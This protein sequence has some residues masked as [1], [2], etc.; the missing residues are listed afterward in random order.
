MMPIRLRFV[1]LIALVAVWL[2]SGCAAGGRPADATDRDV[3]L[4]KLEAVGLAAGEKL[5]V[6]ATTGLVGDVVANVAGDTIELTTLMAPGQDPHGFQPTPR[7]LAAVERAHVVF[8]NGFHLEEGLESTIDA[9]S[10]RGRPVVAISAG[11]RPRGT[12]EVHEGSTPQ[13]AGT[14]HAHV[15]GDPHVWFDPAN[16]KIWAQNVATSLSA[17]DPAHAA[18][19][20]ANAAAYAG[21]LDELDAFIRA[22]VARIPA[23]R[24]KLVTDHD[25]FGYFA[26]RYGFRVIGAVIPALSTTA[27]PSAGDLAD[28]ITKIRAERVPAVF[29]GSQA[30]ARL[31]EL[32]A[33]ETGAR[34]LRLYTGELGPAGSGAETYIGMM[35]VDVERIVDGLGQP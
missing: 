4:P 32:V 15:A 12:G 2:A 3:R 9:A 14:D 28:L 25:A 16:V 22:Q 17:L 19:Y 29:I 31:P 35:R 34:V 30:N 20:Q 10:S 6:V 26:D 33:A 5:R 18:A 13:A 11:I 21:Q 7:D 8:I 27:E 23:E 24:R 1:L